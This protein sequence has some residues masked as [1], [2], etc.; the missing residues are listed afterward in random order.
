MTTYDGV[1]PSNDQICLGF[2]VYVA[3]GDMQ[4][5]FRASTGDDASS[6]AVLGINT[7]AQ[8]SFLT[9]KSGSEINGANSNGPIEHVPYQDNQAVA[10]SA[11]L[12]G[13]N[14]LSVFVETL[15]QW[16]ISLGCQAL[17]QDHIWTKVVELEST[18]PPTNPDQLTV[19]PRIYGERHEPEI[20]GQVL[21]LTAQNLDLKSVVH[22]LCGGIVA[23]ISSMM[24]PKVLQEN[25]ITKILASGECLRRHPA[26]QQAIIKEYVGCQVQFVQEGHACVGAALFVLDHMKDE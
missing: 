6:V 7:S 22:G 17:S 1:Y 26:L 4:S 14:V 16:M 9:D 19:C 25:G 8:L 13:G 20:R 10:V 23:N 21:N 11:C 24:S 15:Q 18:P 12:N 3:T 5:A 2:Q